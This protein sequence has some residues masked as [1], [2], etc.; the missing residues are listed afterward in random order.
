MKARNHDKPIT[1]NIINEVM[2]LVKLNYNAQE[3]ANRLG[4]SKNS[5]YNITRQHRI[6]LQKKSN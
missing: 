4:R 2:K 3:I 1:Q 6:D 5:I